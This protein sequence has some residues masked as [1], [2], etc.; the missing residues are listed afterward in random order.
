MESTVREEETMAAR[1]NES[2]PEQAETEPA[3]PAEEADVFPRTVRTTFEPGRD[4]V[5]SETEYN[6]LRVQGVLT[7]NKGN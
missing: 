3:P 2:A 6:E 5:V 4:I 7:E 1:K